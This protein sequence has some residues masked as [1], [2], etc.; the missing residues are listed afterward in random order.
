MT[1]KTINVSQAEPPVLNWLVA[2]AANP[3]SVT[4]DFTDPRD[5]WIEC[6]G[7]AD[8]PLHSYT[9]TTDWSQG[10]PL[11]S[12]ARIESYWHSALECWAAKH[13]DNLRCGPTELT[14]KARCFVASKLGETVEVP[15]ELCTPST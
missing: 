6:D 5:P 8:Q 11:F 2:K 12:E 10:G 13:D 1:M 14:A 3:R 9:P 7:I 4:L 15:E